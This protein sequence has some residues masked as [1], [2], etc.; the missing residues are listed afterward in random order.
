M[1]DDLVT[2]FHSLYF[3][4]SR[5]VDFIVLAR[6]SQQEREEKSL[7]FGFSRESEDGEGREQQN[8]RPIK[9]EKANILTSCKGKARW[10]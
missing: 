6:A 8:K 10:S 3:L 4:D 1:L 5:E 9:A 2:A 7:T